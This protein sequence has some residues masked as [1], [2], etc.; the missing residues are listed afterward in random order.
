VSSLIVRY[1][2]LTQYT[3][4]GEPSST[5]SHKTMGKT[6][7]C[8][9]VTCGAADVRRMQAESINGIQSGLCEHPKGA[10]QLRDNL[11]WYTCLCGIYHVGHHLC[12]MSHGLLTLGSDLRR[13]E[14]VKASSYTTCNGWCKHAP[15]A[16][17][18]AVLLWDTSQWD[19]T[20][21]CSTYITRGTTVFDT[22]A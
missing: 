1:F 17:K 11:G 10:V 7:A 5:H 22:C 18:G 19:S 13:R 16:A 9:E 8:W 2:G 15:N 14:I 6:M 20:F 21:L 4:C 12:C 3:S